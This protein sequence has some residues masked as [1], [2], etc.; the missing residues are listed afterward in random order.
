MSFN[1]R[2]SA[3]WPIVVSLPA[4]ILFALFVLAPTIGNVLFSFTNFDGLS[5]EKTKWIGLDNY[6]R[7]LSDDFT[8]LGQ[9][10][11]ITLLFA[12]LVTTIQHG[13]A[14]ALSVLVNMKL[15]LRT[16]YRATIFLPNILGVVVV[17]LIWTLMFDPYSGPINLL[18]NK[19]GGDSALLGD[20]QIA[21]YL[22]IFVTIWA[23]VGFA[24]ILYLAGL[25]GI[26]EELYEAGR[27]DGTT[28]WSEF[29]HITVPMLRPIITINLMFSIIGTLNVYDIIIVLT[30]GGPSN[31]TRTIGMYIFRSL[32]D[33]LSQGYISAIS[34]IHFLSVFVVVVIFQLYRRR[35]EVD[36]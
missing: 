19:F 34:V 27:M 32:T 33:G 30:N 7:A 13:L 1:R 9:A 31:S 3:F 10:L 29:R 22:V 25:Q 8:D 28:R 6:L 4:F 20:L 21:L 5:L 26:P 15:R 11:R 36:L 18:L 23:N 12:V 2:T 24:M 35:K 14:L 16:F 17:G